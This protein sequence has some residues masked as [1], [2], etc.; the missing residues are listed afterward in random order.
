LSTHDPSQD[1]STGGATTA[2]AR[3]VAAVTGATG[4]LGS[5]LVKG[6]LAEGYEV[7][8]HA[9]DAEKARHLDRRVKVFIG[10]ICDANVLTEMSAGCDWVFHTVSNFRT[11]AGPPESYRRVNVEGTR[12]A[13][14]AAAAAGVKRFIHC[15][16]IGVHGDVRE[17]PATENA[18]FNPGDLYQE[19]KLEAESMVRE[20]VGRWPME[21]VVV[22]PCSMYG[23]GDLRMLKMFRMLTKRTFFKAGPCREN[24]HAVYID[25]VVNGFLRAATAPDIS[26]EVFFIGGASFL[27]LDEYINVAAR[28]V[29][30]P[31]PFLRVP[32][33]L[34]HSAAWLCERIFV[35]LGLE[36]PLHVRR[37]RFFKN[38]RAFS[39][40][41]ARRVLGYDPQVSLEDGMRRTV[42]WYREQG[43]LA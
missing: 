39:I 6:L 31:K 32:Y 14:E 17:T 30:A 33:G 11:A 16:T 4:F 3:K 27:P 26:G 34:L 25:D 9:R 22:R 15:S 8:A 19:T 41:K 21:I 29:G 37:V 40:E 42:D 20:A 36:P 7:R 2:A 12:T 10:D 23:P 35:P 1:F 43:Y 13:L 28:A 38:N 5:N 18:P 24:F